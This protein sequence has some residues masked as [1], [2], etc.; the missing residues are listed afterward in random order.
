M[1]R[2]LYRLVILLV[3]VLMATGCASPQPATEMPATDA[4]TEPQVQAP[5]SP[6]EQPTATL[7]TVPL[8][9]SPSPTAS[10]VHKA[11]P[12]N[13]SE[14]LGKGNDQ[15]S[16]V[17]AD[18]Q[19]APG[20]D[21]YATGNLERPFNSEAMD[22]Y[23][24]EIDIQS[25]EL[26]EDA[27][28]VYLT[29][30]LKGPGQDGRF[31]G[32]YGLE[33]DVDTDGR[34]DFLVLATNPQTADWSTDG[35]QAWTDANDDVGNHAV[36][37]SDPP[38]T[39]NGYDQL[40]F[41]QGVGDDPDLAWSRLSPDDSNSIQIAVKKAMFNDIAYL[42]G[43]WAGKSLDPAWF[44]L[45]DHFTFAEAGSPIVEYEVYYPL[46]SLSE[47]DNTCRLPAGFQPL[48]SEPALCSS[49]APDNACAPPPGGCRYGFNQATCRCIQG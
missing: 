38:Q 46:K 42:W 22:V 15:D 13:P 23:Y 8:P 49:A 10:I 2:T 9:P 32:V 40:L 5:T 47:V 18:K 33:I 41:D 43:V 34:G 25:M 29:I 11:T 26:G 45:V 27:D 24:P 6:P 48:G 4:P 37:E 35:V 30:I 44:D 31:T 12:G 16:S 28:W 19:R 36:P 1:S 20:G 14:S 7:E 21:F 17:T 39:G 3:V